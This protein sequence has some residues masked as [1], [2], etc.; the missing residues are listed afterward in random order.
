[1]RISRVLGRFAATGAALACGLVAL[2]PT[3]SADDSVLEQPAYDALRIQELRDRGV[4]G[5]G[6]T[7]AVLESGV[8]TTVPEL[9]DGQIEVKAPGCPFTSAPASVEHG[10]MVT[11]ILK[12]PGWGLAPK[13]KV[14]VYRDPRRGDTEPTCDPEDLTAEALTNVVARAVD[15]GAD[16][17]NMSYG[18]W[19]VTY[20]HLFD[21][22]IR[23]GVIVVIGAGND[24][25][26]IPA[27]D[28]A[29]RNGIVVVTS[30]SPITREFSD[31]SSF[32]KSVT[33]TA[34][35]EDLRCRSYD[36]NGAMTV[37]K[38]GCRGTSYAAPYVVGALALAKQAHPQATGNQLMQ[39][40]IKTAAKD[41][42]GWDEHFGWGLVNIRGM[43]DDDP[44]KYPDENPFLDRDP[45]V[46][47]NAQSRAVYDAGL[48]SPHWAALGKDYV[49]RGGDSLIA[50]TYS[51]RVAMGT[52]PA[53]HTKRPAGAPVD[54]KLGYQD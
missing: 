45:D 40:L 22:A 19:D 31:F 42:S 44:S 3:A 29:S 34:P 21:Y 53:F 15:D 50:D 43:L 20:E 14:V 38:E 18:G 52:S 51:D 25:S 48:V 36:A 9:R 37:V 39:S 33:V 13:A 16:I 2:T 1:M 35:G 26:R 5:T 24:A 47:P 6:V 49:Y 41:P 46:A 28:I 32:G 11:S 12:A 54:G 7:I 30:M 4:D 8:D 23:H 17:I 10:T 27:I